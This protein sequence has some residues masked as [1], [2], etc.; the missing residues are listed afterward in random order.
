MSPA[1]ATTPAINC[2]GTVRLA[3]ALEERR[4]HKTLCR[5]MP[6]ISVKK[7]LHIMLHSP[8]NSK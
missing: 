3:V 2:S 8:G 4:F 6:R 1:E 7:K 5:T